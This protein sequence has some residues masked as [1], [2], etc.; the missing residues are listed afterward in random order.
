M[1]AQLK[2]YNIDGDEVGS[3]EIA[4]ELTKASANLQMIKDYLVA[5]RTNQRQW[6]ANTKTR[7]EI[8]CTKKKPHPQK[9][10]GRAR[11]GFLGSPQFR[12]GGRVGSPRPKFDQHVRINKK[13]KRAAVAHLLTEKV[14]EGHVHVLE[15][16]IFE[17]PKTKR[18]ANFLQK[19]GINGRRVLFLAEGYLEG[20]KD[21][22]VSPKQKYEN[23][24]KS[25]RNLPKVSF[26]LMPNISGY[27][28]ALNE[29][30]VVIE[31]AVDELKILL[32]ETK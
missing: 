25:L 24:A 23:F 1:S 22:V 28:A 10:S 5:L 15:C 8:N 12:G 30:I 21:V 29:E 31:P 26:L 13:E 27:E 14:T 6:S 4:G 18:I 17:A 3:I 19:R 32:K 9:G 16:P 11:Q 2:K 7:A 20:Q